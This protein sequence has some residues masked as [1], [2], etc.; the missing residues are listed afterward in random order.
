MI[1]S[2][3]EIEG[4]KLCRLCIINDRTVDQIYLRRIH[5]TALA[6]QIRGHGCYGSVQVYAYALHEHF[7]LLKHRREMIDV[8]SLS[9][10]IITSIV[11]PNSPGK[12]S[13]LCMS[14]YIEVLLVR[15]IVDSTYAAS[16]H[17][18]RVRQ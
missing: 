13:E 9:A 5:H 1:G 4:H 2:L 3:A 18:L 11:Q 12:R 16:R 10:K 17:I 15:T 8:V 6:V 7:H 14:G